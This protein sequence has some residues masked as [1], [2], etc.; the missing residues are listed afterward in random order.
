MLFLK[1]IFVLSI[2]LNLVDGNNDDCT[3]GSGKCSDHGSYIICYLN[4]NNNI[5]L[6]RSLLRSCTQQSSAQQLYVDK[7]YLSSEYGDLVINIDLPSSIHALFIRN[8]QDR[9][10]FRLTASNRNTGLTRIECFDDVLLESQDFFNNFVQLR[11][12]VFTSLVSK[13][14]P[15][16]TR[17]QYLTHLTVWTPKAFQQPIDS[18]MFSALTNLI[19]LDLSRSNFNGITH[20]AFNSLK[21]LTYL[22]LNYNEIH[23]ISDSSL[24]ELLELKQLHLVSN[25]IRT[26]SNYVF[27]DLAQLSMLDLNDNPGFPLE[28]LLHA[29][30]VKVLH[31]QYNNYPTLDPFVFQQLKKLT[32]EK[33]NFD[34]FGQSISM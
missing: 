7:S 1:F 11:N 20:G 16:F 29:K 6:V 13:M 33:I 8:Y 4:N 27:K 31:L 19:A 10:Y 18:S 17:L 26:I 21:R 32:I 23:H 34:K 22:S 25:E 14:R 24:S 5:E 3:N 2:G 28:T 9:D 15:S 12:I 30:S